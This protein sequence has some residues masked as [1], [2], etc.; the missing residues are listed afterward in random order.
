MLLVCGVGVIWDVFGVD[1][2]LFFMFIVVFLV[3][4][5]SIWLFNLRIFLMKVCV[6]CERNFL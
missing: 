4:M 6:I 1:E 3:S 5:E 2:R